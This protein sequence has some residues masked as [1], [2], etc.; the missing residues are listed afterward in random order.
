MVENS[1]LLLPFR[2][3]FEEKRGTKISRSDMYRYP[4]LCQGRLRDSFFASLF[5]L[6]DCYKRGRL[7]GVTVR[8]VACCR[9]DGGSGRVPT[10]CLP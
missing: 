8:T 5:M 4:P 3:S 10:A 1:K 6:P 2:V 7:C 9:P